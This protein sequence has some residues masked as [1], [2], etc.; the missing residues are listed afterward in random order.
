L[1]GAAVS[2]EFENYRIPILVY[3]RF[4]ETVVDSMTVTTERFESQIR[5]LRDHDHKFVPLRT[6]VEARLKGSP[7]PENTVVFTADDGHRSVYNRLFRLARKYQLPVTLFIYPSAISNAD[8][9]MTWQQLAELKNSGLFEVQSHTFWHPNFLR[10]KRR[11]SPTEYDKFASTQLAQSKKILESKLGG[12]VD[13]LAWPFGI[14]D[15]DLIG[16]AEQ[17]GY[18]AGFT[19]EGRHVTPRDHMMTLPRYLMTQVIDMRMFAELMSAK[20]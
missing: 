11:L 6:L 7:L 1:R 3:H 14:Y 9:A 8:Y 18:L 15:D 16:K 17:A 2:G 12:T 13:L 10:E 5:Y 19:I 20:R 4:N